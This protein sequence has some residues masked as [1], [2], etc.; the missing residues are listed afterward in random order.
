M[1]QAEPGNFKLREGLGELMIKNKD[2]SGSETLYQEAMEIDSDGANAQTARARLAGLALA[3]KS[4]DKTRGWA[5]QALEIEPEN[6]QALINLMDGNSGAA[7]PDLRMV[8]RSEPG[9]I[10]AMLLLAEP[11]RNTGAVTEV[12]S[13]DAATSL[14]GAVMSAEVALRKGDFEKAI[15]TA[16][17]ACEENKAAF[18]PVSVIM[19]ATAG[20]GDLDAAIAAGEAYRLEQPEVTGINNILAQLYL[21]KQQPSKA[22]TILEETIDSSPVLIQTYLLLARLHGQMGNLELREE[23]LLKGS[24]ANPSNIVM[25]TELA[26]QYLRSG[27]IEE[28][29][30][31]LEEAYLIDENSQVVANNLL[32]TAQQGGGQGVEY[33][34]HLSMA[35]HKNGDA[36]L[37]KEQLGKALQVEGADFFGKDEA[38][39]AYNSL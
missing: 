11:Q 25:R 38:E 6:T 4:L 37:A 2:M 13:G 30:N 19:R 21:A 26:A 17:R 23:L 1:V 39:K 10:P 18:A 29:L 32:K 5:E 33:W 12:L 24:A 20:K 16:N 35:Y 14:A 28:A 27:E 31:L 15:N 22:V 8:L 9:S 34:Y 3:A 36:E 7:I